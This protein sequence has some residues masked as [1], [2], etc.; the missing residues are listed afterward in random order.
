MKDRRQYERIELNV[1]CRVSAAGIG[2]SA[3]NA[4]MENI[5][6]NGLLFKINGS[7]KNGMPVVGDYLAVDILLPERRTFGKKSL[8]CRGSVVRVSTTNSDAR[9][10]VAV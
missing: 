3:S 10:A 6:R 2:I 9:I 8:R 1:P 7:S 4:V 5:S